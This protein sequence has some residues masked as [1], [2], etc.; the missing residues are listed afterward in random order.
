MESRSSK[1]AES[2]PP[3]RKHPLPG[4]PPVQLIRF[5]PPPPAL[6]PPPTTLPLHPEPERVPSFSYLLELTS[7]FSFLLWRSNDDF[8][9]VPSP[10]KPTMGTTRP[11]RPESK[12]AFLLL[13]LVAARELRDLG[14]GP[15]GNH[16]HKIS[17]E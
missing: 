1:G 9:V 17:Y 6:A 12:K 11:N 4:S 8:L 14:T 16:S 7:V 5:C 3:P 2:L 13:Q 10:S 15:L